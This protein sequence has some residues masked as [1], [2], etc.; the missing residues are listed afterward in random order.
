MSL[1]MNKFAPFVAGLIIA[2]AAHAQLLPTWE[3]NITLTQQDLDMIHGAVTN[4]VHGKPVG[5]TAS[6]SNPASG[7]SGSIKLV[8]KLTLKNQRCEDIEYTVR[9]RR[10]AGLHR[11]LS[12]YQ[13]SAARRDLENRVNSVVRRRCAW[14]R[15][16]EQKIVSILNEANDLTIATVREDGYPQATTVSYVN[17]GLTIYFGC[18]AISKGQE[19]R[20]QRQGLADGQPAI[21]QLGRDPGLS[22]GGKAA[23]VTDP[24]EMDRVGRLMLRKFPQI[25]RYAPTDMEQ[26]VVF[27]ITPEIISVLDYRKGFGHTD[28]VKVVA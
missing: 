9:S 10:H 21:R 19:H 28:L 25:A 11:A 5:T 4:Q 7:N 26:L 18:A 15:Q 6:W 27:R 2:G 1:R 24:K 17:D 22:I 23:R 14:T 16:L 20:A 8:K 12:F 13:L 3:T